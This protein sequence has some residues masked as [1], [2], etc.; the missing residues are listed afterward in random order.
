[1]LE[2]AKLKTAVIG[3]GLSARTFHLPFIKLQPELELVAISSSQPE[4]AIDYPQLSHYPDANALIA[5]SDAGL[6]VI[7]S[8]NHSHFPLAKAALQQGKHVLL[9]KPLV[10]SSEEGQQLT[11]IAR[12]SGRKLAVYHN[13]RFDG[14]FLTLQQLI[15]SGELGNIHYFE[16]HFDRFRPEP[17]ARWREQ[18]GPGSGILWDLGPHLIDQTLCLFG[19]PRA[20][21]ANCRTLRPGGESTDYFHLQLHYPDKEVVLHSSPF[22]ASP[23]LRFMLQGT[24]GSYQKFG[25]DPQEDAL[26]AGAMPGGTD[27]GL[28]KATDYGVL[29]TVDSQMSYPTLA[30]NYALF[31]QQLVAALLHDAELPVPVVDALAGIR[32]IELAILSSELGLRVEVVG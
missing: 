2:T 1:M 6:V 16:S 32:L 19:M 26:R 13:R 29:A 21:T 12:Q 3:Y 4:L 8:P 7:T 22:C 27:W 15:R 11:A 28:E 20:I 23:T 5:N 10:L 25:L 14:D 9:E 31:Y 17:R 30:G 18:A 24:K